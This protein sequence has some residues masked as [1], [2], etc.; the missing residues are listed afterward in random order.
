M[1]GS[2]NNV[3]NHGRYVVRAVLC[4]VNILKQVFSFYI[5]FTACELCVTCMKPCFVGCSLGFK[6]FFE[7]LSINCCN[8]I[9]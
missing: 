6:Y 3:G 2:F 1:K 5:I 8:P 9:G 4:H 7:C